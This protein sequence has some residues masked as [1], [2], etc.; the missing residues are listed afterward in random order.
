MVGAWGDNLYGELTRPTSLNGVIA[1]AA[2]D[3]HSLALKSEGTVVAWGDNSYGQSTVPGSLTGVFSIAAG[4]VYNIAPKSE[5]EGLP[6]GIHRFF[7]RT[8]RATHY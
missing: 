1:V 6:L 2:G 8:A 5:G 7:P 4:W 3:G